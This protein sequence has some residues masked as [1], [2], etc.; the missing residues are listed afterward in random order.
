MYHEPACALNTAAFT[1]LPKLPVYINRYILT[2]QKCQC[3]PIGRGQL[4]I[5]S[6]SFRFTHSL[7]LP[8][9]ELICSQEG[10]SNSRDLLSINRTKRQ[11]V[12]YGAGGC[13]VNRRFTLPSMPVD[14]K[15]CQFKSSHSEGGE[16]SLEQSSLLARRAIAIL[17]ANGDLQVC[18][19]SGEVYELTLPY[20][21]KRMVS[22]CNGLLLQRNMGDENVRQCLW[23]SNPL[24]P[25]TIMETNDRYHRIQCVQ[26]LPR[27]FHCVMKHNCF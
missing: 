7:T 11:V 14:A 22:I 21:I 6:M 24:L 17:L 18:M 8:K 4:H 20:P 2:F 9:D 10:G 27:R 16:S 25:L 26:I 12:W 13:K 19:Y 23:M 1:P 15:F 5:G 3:S